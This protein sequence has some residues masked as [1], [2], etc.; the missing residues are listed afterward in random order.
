MAGLRF[1]SAYLPFLPLRLSCLLH[2]LTSSLSRLRHGESET[3]VVRILSRLPTKKLTSVGQQ[4]D[5]G[6]TVSLIFLFVSYLLGPSG[7]VKINFMHN[8]HLEKLFPILLLNT[9]P[10]R[11][12]SHSAQGVC[13]TPAVQQPSLVFK[14]T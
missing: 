3:A 12:Q 4:A 14:M 9:Q 2:F 5:T 10:Q 11:N 1:L 7:L 6:S 8:S 13:A